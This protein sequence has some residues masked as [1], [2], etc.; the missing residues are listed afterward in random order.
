MTKMNNN[1]K[2]PI[3]IILPQAIYHFTEDVKLTQCEDPFVY[4]KDPGYWVNL[5]TNKDKFEYFMNDEYWLGHWSMFL[6]LM[7]TCEIYRAPKYK[8]DRKRK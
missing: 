7:L 5:E 4:E 2:H 1:S 6:V 3:D 8:F